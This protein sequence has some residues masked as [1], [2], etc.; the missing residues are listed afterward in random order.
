[1]IELDKN[2]EKWSRAFSIPDVHK[3]YIGKHIFDQIGLV[4][5]K[6]NNKYIFLLSQSFRKN[7]KANGD[8]A[9]SQ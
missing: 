8:S 5:K 7:F 6:A 9:D 4:E 3:S 1:M 2:I